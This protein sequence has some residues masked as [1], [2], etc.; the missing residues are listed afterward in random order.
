MTAQVVR[1]LRLIVSSLR[2]LLRDHQLIFWNF[3][4]FF[5]LLV[6]F[7][8]LLSHGE[9]AVR[10]TLTAS[11]V[12]IGLTA[13]ALF[14]VGVG[15]TAARQDG[16]FRRYAM[17]PL[18]AGEPIAAAVAARLLLV[19]FAAVAQ[20]V[21][22]RVLFGVPW[23]GGAWPWIVLVIAGSAAFSAIGFLIAA[24]ASAVHVAN[25]MVN[26]VFI[27]VVALSGTSLPASMMP[28]AWARM[29]WM[30]PA[31]PIVD[32]LEHAFVG[33]GI[34]ADLRPLLY[35]AAWTLVAGLAGARLWWRRDP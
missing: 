20:V 10:V 1:P 35:L 34:T 11:I 4:F 17:T 14:G 9:I 32:G 21:V 29:R 22:A 27:P 12:T 26:L 33:G 19:L 16:V 8:G 18:P 2:L 31:A 30:L 3:G 15:L 13:N 24:S 28:A 5:A 7:L 6:V 23:A 25:R